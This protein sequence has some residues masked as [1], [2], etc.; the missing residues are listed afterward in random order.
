MSRPTFILLSLCASASASPIAVVLSSE[1]GARWA[2]QPPLTWGPVSPTSPRNVTV[3]AAIDGG[4]PPLL[5]FGG[6][7]TDTSAY[8]SEVFM[9]PSVR[10]AF[11]EA[12]WGESGLRYTLGRVHINSPDYSFASYNLDNVTGDFALAHF[13]SALTYDSQ[14]VI[15]LLRSAA[16]LSRANGRA[17]RLFGSPWSPPAWL[18]K[19]CACCRDM[20]CSAAPPCL[21]EDDAAGSYKAT[22]AAYIVRWLD[23]FAAH[24]LPMW[25][26]TAQNEPEAIQPNFESCAYAPAD[27]A[28]FIGGYLGPAL[29]AAHPDLLL[30]AYDHNK[31]NALKWA[32]ALLGNASLL[33]FV[34]GF[35]VHWYDY[36]TS[37]GLENVRAIRA[38]L[39]PDMPLFN[40]ESCYLSS[41]VTDW[42]LSELY[43]ADIFGDLNFGANGWMQWN[44]ALLTGDKYPQWLGGPN[45]DGTRQFGDPVL[46]EYNASGAQRLILQPSYYIVGHVSR[47]ALPG[48]RRL[49]T[50]GAG[51]AASAA[52]YDAVRAAA[53]GKAP[54]ATQLLAL[55][56]AAA[57]GGAKHAVVANPTDAELA[58]QLVD[59][60]TGLAAEATLPAHAIATFSWQA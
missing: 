54:A 41:L 8:N 9:S 40:S 35:A 7:F 6:A 36:G 50:A 17:L 26:L 30:L 1:A 44:H 32:Q 33:P 11:L 47:V 27:M 31:L 4:T 58:F 10:E 52:E 46:L 37:L 34:K 39:G 15:P 5:G 16:A 3:S 19:P 38:M 22:W 57:E 12:Y 2:P 24:G 53:L 55:A 48:A 18:K 60:A 42:R 49:A 43:A 56:F 13:D 14:R 20:I 45:H 28:D 29:A 21:R 59:A 25:G 51:V 23:A